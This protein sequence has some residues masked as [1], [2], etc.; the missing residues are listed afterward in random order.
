MAAPKSPREMML[1]VIANMPEKTGR[2]LEEW[3]AL[4]RKEGP[5]V[6]KEQMAWLKGTHGVGHV[7]ASIIVGEVAQEGSSTA[8]EKTEDLLDGMYSGPY[9]P[10]RPVYDDLMNM[11]ES[12]GD[13]ISVSVCK[14]YVGLSRRRQFAILKPAGKNRVDVG[15]ALPEETKNTGRLEKAGSSMGSDRMTRR[16]PVSSRDEID[17]EVKK[18]LR[19]AYDLAG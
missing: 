14:T 17:A 18:W 7:T 2:T 19:A 1:A 9:A 13:D 6:R 15:L 4:V 3:V 16:V 5:A 8:Y 12:F 11:A 10:L